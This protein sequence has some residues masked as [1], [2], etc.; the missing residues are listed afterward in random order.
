MKN[1]KLKSAVL[2]IFCSFLIALLL[3]VYP[4]EAAS[5]LV[6][7]AVNNLQVGLRRKSNVVAT[8]SGYM[9]VFYNGK[10]VGIEYYDNNF[11]IQSKKTIPMELE[12]WGGFYDG[13]DAYYLVEGQNNKEEKDTAEVIRVIKYDKNWNKLKAANITGN[14]ELFGG[15]VRYPFDYGCVEF[16]ERSGTLYIVTGHEGYV[17]EMVGQG[18][19]GFLMIAVDKASMTGKIVACDLWH[20][21]AQY[22]ESRDSNLY[23]L[24]QSEGSRCTT[25]T[26]YNADTLERS[27]LSVLDYGGSHTSSWAIACYASVDGMALSADHILCL[28]T[29]IDQSKYDS[30]TSDTAHNIYLTVTPMN[31]FSKEA[32]AV[33]W[34]TNYS[35]GGKSFLGTK[36][37]KI[38]DNRFMISWEEYNTGGTASTDDALSSSILHYIYVDGRGNKI[39]KEF[40]E[41]T[42]VSDCQPIVKDSKVVYYASNENTVNFY[43]IDTVSGKTNKKVY[44]VAGENATWS[45]AGGVLTISG[46]GE[47]AIDEESF[48]RPVSSTQ[49]GYVYSIQRWS[50][51][52]DQVKKIVIKKGITSISE[53]ALSS[54]PNL[55]EVVIESGLKSIGKEAFYGCSELRKITIP[56]SVK[57]IGDDILWTGW[58]WMG[59]KSHVVY[60]SIYAEDNSAAVKYAKKNN[61]GYFIILDKAK[62]S[63]LKKSYTYSGKKLEPKVT[64]KL[65]S[66][67][68][69]KDTDY[70]VTYKNN[71]KAGTATVEVKGSGHYAGKATAKFKIVLPGAG[72]KLTDSKTKS[73]YTVTKE[74]TTVAYADGKKVKAATLSIPSKIKLRGVTYEV[75]SIADHAFKDNK[76]LKSVTISG[77][78]TGI[79]TGA[80]QGC[81][82]L[83]TVKTGAKVTTIGKNA[84]YGC[85]KLTAVTL[86]K[87][88]ASIGNSAFENCTAIKKITIP[89]KVGKIGS[90]A[91]YNCT[92]LTS[93]TIQTEK[94]T[95]KNVGSKAFTK[96]GKSNYKKMTVKVPK[97]SFSAYRKWLPQKGLTTK[98]KIKK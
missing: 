41:A 90:R 24:E 53:R 4:S 44:R 60:A 63:G 12:L 96:T 47:I 45:F 22:I 13:S 37:T 59:D 64:V 43:S 29:S 56:S 11:N 21:F 69:K 51:I 89:A 2:F 80:F 78:V 33:K 68:L 30:V 48:R 77:K 14:P 17:D 50:T 83:Q 98:A 82:A 86:G 55:T 85:K 5:G 92:G 75:T 42:P 39:S 93:I 65:G 70:T 8:D 28:G 46:T 94:L 40:T 76:K 18:H 38:N 87:N 73:V 97:K 49:G 10:S 62:I 36:I 20:S 27:T 79:G 16:T 61:I 35:G 6:P 15:E 71:T 74:G 23:V 19:Q 57:E 52:Q 9:R 66:S 81:T 31:N 26:R 25:L 3:P 72:T 32:T 7:S 84:F 34:I 88:V 91:F 1:F 58:Y 54:F 95:A 67:T